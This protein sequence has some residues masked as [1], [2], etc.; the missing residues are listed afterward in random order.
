MNISKQ[1]DFLLKEVKINKPTGPIFKAHTSFILDDEINVFDVEV[2][3]NNKLINYGEG[4]LDDRGN[5]KG[6]EI[7]ITTNEEDENFLENHTK[8]LENIFSKYNINYITERSHNMN[9]IL[10]TDISNLRLKKY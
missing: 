1:R 4:F 6:I 10:I 7:V 3:M 9:V 5:I 8:N 2:M